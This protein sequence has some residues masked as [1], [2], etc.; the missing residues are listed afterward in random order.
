MYIN[1]KKRG[2]YIEI[3]EKG[4]STFFLWPGLENTILK[5]FEHLEG[6]ADM[7]KV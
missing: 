1:I 2:A 3:S 7:I 4:L 5:R 6:L